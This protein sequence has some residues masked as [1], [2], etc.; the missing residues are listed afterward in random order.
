MPEGFQRI[1]LR[2]DFSFHKTKNLI[3]ILAAALVTALY[4]FV[5]LLGSAVEGA[6]LL[7]Y[8]YTYGSTSHILYIGLTEHQAERIAENAD[9]KSVVHLSSLGQLTDPQIGQRS[10]RIPEIEGYGILALPG[11]IG[12]PVSV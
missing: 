11:R 2:R 10:A 3:L 12:R 7:S 4:S 9:V 1:I 8:Q 6:F 5:F